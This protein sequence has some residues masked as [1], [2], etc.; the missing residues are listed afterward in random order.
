M[1]I[2][3][4]I[5]LLQLSVQSFG[6]CTDSTFVG[7]LKK[8]KTIKFN[9]NVVVSSLEREALILSTL[10]LQKEFIIDLQEKSLEY[11]NSSE[12]LIKEHQKLDSLNKEKITILYSSIQEEQDKVSKKNKIIFYHK[13]VIGA[14]IVLKIVGLI[15]I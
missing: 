14:M 2:V 5:L 11:V 3:Y 15:L 12:K 6:Q 8:D 4:I 13:V 10:K 9:C 1:R 7:I